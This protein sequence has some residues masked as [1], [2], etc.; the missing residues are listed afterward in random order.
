MTTTTLNTAHA[1]T[2]STSNVGIAVK[3]LSAAAQ[4]LV[5]ALWAAATQSSAVAPRTLTAFEEAED[6]R[7]FA[8]KLPASERDFACDLYAAADRHEWANK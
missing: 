4:K 7:A 3:E 2:A 1:T 8:A 5:A 6:L